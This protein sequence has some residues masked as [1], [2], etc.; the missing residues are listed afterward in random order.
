MADRRSVNEYLSQSGLPVAAC[1]SLDRLAKRDP[2]L[3]LEQARLAVDARSRGPQ[4]SAPRRHR[5]EPDEIIAMAAAQGRFA[6]SR[7]AF[8]REQ[9]DERPAETTRLLTADPS[10]GGLVA[11]RVPAEPVIS[12]A[13]EARDH[14]RSF[15]ASFP[16]AASALGYEPRAASPFSV[17]APESPV[18]RPGRTPVRHFRDAS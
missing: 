7:A 13:Q 3:A 18:R 11:A 5:A 16:R 17:Q 9:L 15:A 10:E 14:E 12:A 4:A 1:A 6:P 2:D 8:W